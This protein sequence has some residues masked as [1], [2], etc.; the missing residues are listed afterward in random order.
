M[1]SHVF[2]LVDRFL[3]YQNIFEP[4]NWRGV[5]QNSV[6]NANIDNVL[7]ILIVLNICTLMCITH[8]LIHV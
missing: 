2:S 4:S 6:D 8:C 1:S 7:M 5:N 3:E